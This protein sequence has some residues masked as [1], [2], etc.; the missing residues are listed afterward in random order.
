ML[1]NESMS[2]VTRSIAPKQL[3]VNFGPQSAAL[4]HSKET[5]C[6]AL[7]RW[8]HTLRRCAAVQGSSR[9]HGGLDMAITDRQAR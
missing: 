8:Q 6:P 7:P 9:H 5:R 1:A 2:R 3:V 4:L